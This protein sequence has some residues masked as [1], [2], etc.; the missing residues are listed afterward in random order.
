MLNKKQLVAIVMGLGTVS[1]G[2]CANTGAAYQPIVDGP[3]GPK[4]TQDVSDCRGL[5]EQ[6][7]LLN[8]NSKQTALLAAGLTGLAILADDKKNDLGEALLGAVVGGALGA[9]AG[10]M[11]TQDER[12][13]M[14]KNCM[15]GRGHR[16]VG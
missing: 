8:G 7:K 2:G 1:L 12:Q 9:G 16:V 11:E 14:M 3:M 10:A 13:E 4:Y 5:A 15:A 6:R